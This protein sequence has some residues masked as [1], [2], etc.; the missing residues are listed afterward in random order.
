MIAGDELT[1][2]RGMVGSLRKQLD[3]ERE[4][5]MKAERDL[6]LLDQGLTAERKLT[7]ALRL[8]LGKAAAADPAEHHRW[9]DALFIAYEDTFEQAKSWLRVDEAGVMAEG[10]LFVRR[11]ADRQFAAYKPTVPMTEQLR[12]LAA[13]LDATDRDPPMAADSP[14]PAVPLMTG[15]G[16]ELL[17]VC[18]RPEL[19]AARYWSG[20]DEVRL[21]RTGELVV[22]LGAE[23]ERAP[24]NPSADLREQIRALDSRLTLRL[25]PGHPVAS[26]RPTPAGAPPLQVVP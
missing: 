10:R 26:A 18:L 16:A 9:A 5:R 7:A 24:F 1:E 25:V 20:L 8:R 23:E 6:D 21:A 22:R 13:L 2:L 4:R 3:E 17:G 12:D 11:G 14:R 19:D 15:A